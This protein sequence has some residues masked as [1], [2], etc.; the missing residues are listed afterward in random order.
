MKSYNPTTVISFPITVGGQNIGDGSLVIAGSSVIAKTF[1]GSAEM[2]FL[3]IIPQ[4]HMLKLTLFGNKGDS[5][6]QELPFFSCHA[7]SGN[8]PLRPDSIVFILF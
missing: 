2:P 5:N 7:L 8:T 1:S 6:V 3:S 4:E